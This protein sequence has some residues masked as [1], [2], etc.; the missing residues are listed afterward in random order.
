[1]T[2]K[3]VLQVC[4]LDAKQ[5]LEMSCKACGHVHYLTRELICTSAERKF[6]YLDEVECEATCKVR[7]CRGAVRLVILHS[8][9]TSAFIGGLA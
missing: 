6:L 3:T 9:D 1:M 2:W 7:G 5:K 4:D 8:R